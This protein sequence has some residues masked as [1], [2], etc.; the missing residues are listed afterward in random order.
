MEEALI[1]I[2][3]GGQ[4]LGHAFAKL[5]LVYDRAYHYTVNS[6]HF[7]PDICQVNFTAQHS[8]LSG[9]SAGN[10]EERLTS[11]KKSALR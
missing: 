4:F 11:E 10:N 1:T 2:F 8:V 5:Q 3:F 6:S 9:R 7:V